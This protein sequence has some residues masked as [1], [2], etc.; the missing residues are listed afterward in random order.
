MGGGLHGGEDGEGEGCSERDMRTAMQRR[1]RRGGG[2]AGRGL[3]RGWQ[4]RA[5]GARR[6]D[7]KSDG[8]DDELRDDG[9]GD[10]RGWVEAICVI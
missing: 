10:E 7:R 4:R 8:G 2:W 9:G 6:W 5:R 1:A 3:C